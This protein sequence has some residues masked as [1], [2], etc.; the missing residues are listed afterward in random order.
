MASIKRHNHRI[1]PCDADQKHA[2][3]EHLVTEHAGKTLLIVTAENAESLASA[4]SQEDITVCSDNDLEKLPKQDY[5]LLISYDLPDDANVYMTRLSYVKTHAR[6][7]LDEQNRQKLYAIERLLGRSL[8]QEP[9]EGFKPRE[10]QAAEAKKEKAQRK[11]NEAA[12]EGKGKRV[13]TKPS[14]KPGKAH[15]KGGDSHSKRAADKAQPKR[16]PKKIN[17]KSLAT[18][19]EEA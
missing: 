17:V 11:R 9:L 19:K 4:F 7:L 12:K 1:H 13:S 15:R 6:I 8:L 3:L 5:D 16:T 18:K 2:L 14:D 10:L